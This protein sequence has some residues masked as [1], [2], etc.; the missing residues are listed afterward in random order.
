MLASPV[1]WSAGLRVRPETQVVGPQQVRH[2]Q[3]V[4]PG[5]LLALKF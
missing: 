5:H 3:E 2:P 1:Q 4:G